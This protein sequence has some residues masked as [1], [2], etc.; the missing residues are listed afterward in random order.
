VPSVAIKEGVFKTLQITEDHLK[1]LYAGVPYEYFIY[2]SSKLNDVRNFATS[3]HIQIMVVTVGA[4][5]KRDV[6]NLY[7]SSEKTGGEKPIDLI[8]ATRP[9]L[10]VDEPQSV[11]G[12]LKGQGKKA[13]EEMSPLCTLR[14]SATHVYK[15]HMVYRLDAVDAY[16][17]KLVKQIEVASAVVE[18]S[19]N[20]PYVRVLS[21]NNKRGRISARVEIDMQAAQGIN[22]TEIEVMDGDNLEIV[23]NRPIYSNC[24]I[25]EIRTEKDNQYVELRYPGGE[26][27]LVPGE[28]FGDVEPLAVQRQMIRRTIKEHLDKEKRLHPQGIKVL[29]L[30]FIDKVDNY[31]QYDSEGRAVKGSYALIFEEEYKRAAR[32]PEYR[33]LFEGLDID[34]T[35]EEV[36]NGYFSID[37]KGGWS[38]TVETGIAN[39]E[40]AE[41]AYNLIMKEKEKLLSLNTPLKF[42]FSHSALK[43]GWDNPNVFQICTLR[44]IST[45]TERRQTLGRGLRLCV[46]QNGDRIRGFE[47]NTLTVIAREGYEEY[48]ENLQKEIEQDTGYRFGVVE[49][50]QFA[51]ITVITPTSEPGALGFEKSK[52]IWEYLTKEEYLKPNGLVTDKLRMALKDGTLVVPTEFA[53]QLDQIVAV[54]KKAVGRINVKNADDKRSI[55]TRRAVLYS[56]EFKALW[57]RVKH[58]SIYRLNF[59]NE[60]L[61][62]D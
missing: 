24:M 47:I 28:S 49:D 25:G 21:V 44:E 14:Y 15:H 30:F 53:D 52:E 50:H 51:G 33:S 2:N 54:L 26:I 4:I 18:D 34:Q 5:N 19:H 40:N 13:L 39:Q 36:H 31:R 56:P 22:R 16:E 62:E 32:L 48:A 23:T 29:S 9:I 59:D 43:E 6:N 60:K 41:R 61:I 55:K 10:I 42:I 37:K 17:Q 20:K 57:D 38:D 8:K 27:F 1:G 11:D 12:G 3:P 45:E 7:K 46:N 35:A 58:K